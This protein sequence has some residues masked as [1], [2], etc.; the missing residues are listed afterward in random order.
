M[1]DTTHSVY[2]AGADDPWSDKD[3]PLIWFA[4]SDKSENGGF[5]QGNPLS[6]LNLECQNLDT[7]MYQRIVQLCLPSMGDCVSDSRL[8][9]S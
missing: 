3:N 4:Y 6:P 8:A 9:A 1:D 2:L 7:A 5:C